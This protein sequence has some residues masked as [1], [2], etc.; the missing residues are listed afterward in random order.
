MAISKAVV[1]YIIIIVSIIC[2]LVYMNIQRANMRHRV[3]VPAAVTVNVNQENKL[4]NVFDYKDGRYSIKYPADWEYVQQKNG[5]GAVVFSG[6]KDTPAFYS[7][8]N[9]Q[10]VLTKKTGGKFSN[11]NELMSS[12]M[13]DAAKQAK[14]IKFLS[15]GG[16]DISES[17]AH[18]KIHGLI[19][20]E[21][22]RH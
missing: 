10:V 16:V 3:P 7:T 15:E 1:V 18:L 13:R 22:S 19:C 6:K 12:L 5:N 4:S 21:F 2:V 20:P 9:I 14:D 8:V 17:S 11:V